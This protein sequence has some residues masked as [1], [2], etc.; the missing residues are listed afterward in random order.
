MGLFAKKPHPALEIESTRKEGKSDAI[1]EGE[2][3]TVFFACCWMAGQER[4]RVDWER[5]DE[6]ETLMG[7]DVRMALL[8]EEHHYD[9]N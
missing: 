1:A 9:G 2:H 7:R 4:P 8:F 6:G 3:E 5:A